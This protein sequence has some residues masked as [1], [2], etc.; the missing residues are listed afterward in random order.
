[1]IELK[2]ADL[3]TQKYKS[4]VDHWIRTD[5]MDDDQLAQTI[6]ELKIDILIDLAGHT[7]GNRLSVFALKP[8]PVS[9]SW[10][11]GYGYTTKLS[12]IDYFL[13]NEVMAPKGSENLFSEQLWN[14][15]NH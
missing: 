4:Y 3:V 13:T 14:L 1:M 2:K 12:A 7:V 5:G 9:L 10:W 11:I 8:A 6:R 15:D